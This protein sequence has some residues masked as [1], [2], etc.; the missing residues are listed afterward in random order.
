MSKNARKIDCAN[1]RGM[2]RY[3]RTKEIYKK[4]TKEVH[5]YK[6]KKNKSTKEESLDTNCA[7]VNFFILTIAQSN[8]DILFEYLQLRQTAF[9]QLVKQ[10]C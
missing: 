1:R 3:K 4:N 8:V 10:E 9:Q 7:G 5:K 2:I 6:R